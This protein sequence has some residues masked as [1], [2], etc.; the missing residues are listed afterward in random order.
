MAL[1]YKLS[2]LKQCQRPRGMGKHDGCKTIQK[3]FGVSKL[4]KVDALFHFQLK[5]TACKHWSFR[6]LVWPTWH[7]GLHVTRLS[8]NH[9]VKYTHLCI[10]LT[11]LA[12][13]FFKEYRYT[14]FFLKFGH[15]TLTCIMKLGPSWYS[16]L[17]F[18]LSNATCS[19]RPLLAIFICT[20]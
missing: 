20:I 2:N 8:C 14:Q 6:R 10:K 11:K 4:S 18:D 7:H 19:I 16:L 12:L 9:L 17:N 3:S 5:P 1:I 15:L 13:T